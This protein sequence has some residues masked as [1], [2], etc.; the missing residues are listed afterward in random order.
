[1]V[2]DGLQEV[3][4]S[5]LHMIRY[6]TTVSQY[7]GKQNRVLVILCALQHVVMKLYDGLRIILG[8]FDKD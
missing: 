5:T 8:C 2:G 3:Y 7:D 6:C 4:I 1:M